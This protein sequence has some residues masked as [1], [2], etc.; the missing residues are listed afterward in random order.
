MCYAQKKKYT[1]AQGNLIAGKD[2]LAPLVL[3]LAAWRLLLVCHL[4]E[5]VAFGKVYI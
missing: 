1:H 2:G 3:A 5:H 4:C